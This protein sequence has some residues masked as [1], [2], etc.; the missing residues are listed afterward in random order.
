MQHL[1]SHIRFGTYIRIHSLL[2]RGPIE[3]MAEVGDQYTMSYIVI[4]CDQNVLDFKVAMGD[5]FGMQEFNCLNDL[6]C[7][8]PGIDAFYTKVL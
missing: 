7:D 1:R 8:E 3:G 4:M 2:D 6:A 5:A